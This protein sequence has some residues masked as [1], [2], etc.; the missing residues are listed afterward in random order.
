MMEDPYDSLAAY[1]DQAP[2]PQEKKPEA[3]SVP[4]AKSAPADKSA[5][6]SYYP[7]SFDEPRLTPVMDI[8]TDPAAQQMANRRGEAFMRQYNSIVSAMYSPSPSTPDPNFNLGQALE[9]AH[10]S[11]DL[12]PSYKWCRSQADF[13]AQTNHLALEAEDRQI[14]SD[15]PWYLEV[16]GSSLAAVY[17]PVTLVTGA[18]TAAVMPAA[19]P[20]IVTA[21]AAIV[22]AAAVGAVSAGESL[23]T[24]LSLNKFERGTLSTSYHISRKL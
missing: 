17:D 9:S 16:L 3:K 24:Y 14:V 2:E 6:P 23:C 11:E 13:D 8:E 4:A 18:A 10:V 22:T 21:A 1:P 12:I 15:S 5:E 19:A 7:G 20:A